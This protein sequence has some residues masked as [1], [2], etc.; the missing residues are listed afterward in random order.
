[1]DITVSKIGGRAFLKLDGVIV[2]IKDYKISSPMHGRTELEVV[3]GFESGAMEFSSAASSTGHLLQ[4][5]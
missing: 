1:M 3:F 4:T 5:Q 2:E